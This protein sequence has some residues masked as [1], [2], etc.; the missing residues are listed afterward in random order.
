MNSEIC[1][2]AHFYQP[3]RSAEHS[4]LSRIQSSPDGIDWTGRAYEECYAKIAQNKSLEML[5]FDIA[6]GLFLNIYA[7]S[8]RK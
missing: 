6:P 8:I 7:V 3:P 5:S 1:I 2:G 4:D